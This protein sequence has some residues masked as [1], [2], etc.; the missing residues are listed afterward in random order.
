M[1]L[2]THL[3][4]VVKTNKSSLIIT[5]NLVLVSVDSVCEQRTV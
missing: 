5:A 2:E 1:W 3:L 4:L